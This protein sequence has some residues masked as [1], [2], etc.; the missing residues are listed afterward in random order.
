M[1]VK[2]SFLQKCLRP[3]IAEVFCEQET[4]STNSDLKLHVRKKSGATSAFKTVEHQTAGKGTKGRKWNNAEKSMLFSIAEPIS[5]GIQCYPGITIAIGLAVA[6]ALREHG[7]RICLKWPND[8][9]LNGGKLGG[10]LVEVVHSLDKIPH[11]IIGVGL[12]IKNGEANADGELMYSVR[13]LSGWRDICFEQ[14]LADCALHIVRQVRSYP[15]RIDEKLMKAWNEIDCFYNKKVV[16]LTI[17]GDRLESVE[18]GIDEFGRLLL[19]LN[20]SM[21][22]VTDGSIREPDQGKEE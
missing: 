17:D 18:R 15:H 4:G 13:D 11:L 6:K 14:L 16:Y 20:S 10:I 9:W 19:E 12:N 21:I 8:L 2:A 7:I 5:K 3:E 22:R 1:F